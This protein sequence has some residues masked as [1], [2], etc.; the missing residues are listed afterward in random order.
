MARK[1][2][3]WCGVRPGLEQVVTAIGDHA[4]VAVLAAA[5]QARER[6][7]VEQAHQVVPQRHLA[8]DV[9]RQ[10]VV[11]VR[12]VH[13]LEDRRHLELHRRDLVVAGLHRTPRR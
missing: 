13:V 1:R 2:R 5:V 3:F 10:R 11:V 7:L 6:L 8:R 4:P 12:D 9:H